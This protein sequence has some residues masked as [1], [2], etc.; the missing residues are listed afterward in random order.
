MTDKEIKRARF[1]KISAIAKLVLLIVI[2]VGIPL[3]IFFFHHDLIDRFSD[4]REIERGLAEYKTESIFI[5]IGAQLLQI[6]ICI[7]PGQELQFAAGY[8]YGFWLGYAFSLIGA[9]LGTIVTYYL[10]RLLGHDAMHMIFGEEKMNSVVEQIRGKKGIIII[11][12]IY[13]IPGVPKDLCN[14]AA[15]LSEIRLDRFLIVSLIGRS[16]GMMGSLLIGNQLVNG[17]YTSAIVIGI[18]AV[19]LCVLGLIF[20]KKV[21]ELF[22]R[23]YEKLMKL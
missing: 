4:I 3:Y 12:L 13:L 14:Y 20:R 19:V 6:I 11:F 10:A 2:L 17:Q 7:I 21:M 8:M 23:F 16:P 18:V 15:G 5:Y 22:D 9:A 1:K